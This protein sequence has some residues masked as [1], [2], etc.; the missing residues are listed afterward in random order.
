MIAALLAAA[1]LIALAHTAPLPFVLELFHRSRSMWRVPS[2]LGAP[3]VYL[4]FDDGPNPDWT[5]TLLDVLRDNDVRA[6]FFLIDRHIT[7]ATAAIVRR[8]AD[9]GHGIGLHSGDRWLMLRSAIVMSQTIENAAARIRA[10]TGHQPCRMFRPLGGWRSASMY[11]G[12][13]KAGYLLVGWSWGM[14]DWNWWRGPD[15]DPLVGRL[16]ASA[17]AGSIL[18]IHDGHHIDPRANR[19]HSIEVVR[20]LIPPLRDRGFGFGVLCDM[21]R[22][23]D[24]RASTEARPGE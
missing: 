23:D 5:P 24:R 11:A 1:G 8:I 19:R 21:T 9:E 15:V 10:I 17:S 3:T 13:I 22:T 4:T 2:R 14:W 6:T 12:L 18:V 16:V 7:P 20:R